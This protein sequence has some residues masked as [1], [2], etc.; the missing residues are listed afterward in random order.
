[1]VAKVIKTL[2]DNSAAL[3]ALIPILSRYPY[4]INT[5]TDFPAMVYTVDRVDPEYD[6]SG[7]VGDTCE[8]SI[9]TFTDNYTSLQN[10]VSE[11]RSALE[12]KDGTISGIDIEFIYLIDQEEG[13]NLEEACFINKLTFKVFIT[14]Y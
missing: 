9:M 6:K 11:V 12:L 4:V 5:D 13:Y 2:L 1:M 7:W 10:I 3:N 14:K 8:F